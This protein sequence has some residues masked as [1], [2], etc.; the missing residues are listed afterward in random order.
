MRR[1]LYGAVLM[2]ALTGVV[3]CVGM[4]SK[5]GQPRVAAAA[6]ESKQEKS[7]MEVKVVPW[8][9]TQEVIDAASNSVRNNPAIVARL[10][11]TRSR[12]LTLEMLNQDVK[13]GK[14]QPPPTRF[15]ATFY[16]YTHDQTIVAEGSF[17]NPERLEIA[18][19][20]YQPLPSN[21]EFDEAVKILQQ[22]AKLG[23]AIQDGRLKTYPPMPPV[24]YSERTRGRL[25]RT[26]TV[27]LI[28]N[29]PGDSTLERQNEVVGVNLSRNAVLR[30]ATG[31]PPTSSAVKAADCS[32]PPSAGSS[33]GRGV[34]GQ[35]Q[36][37]ISQNG[38][39]LWN[40][41]AVRPSA[42]SGSDGSAIELINVQYKGKQV[43]KRAHLPI[44]NVLY[45]GNTCGPYR[46]WQYAENQFNADPTNGTNVAAGVR[47]CTVP[48]TTVL[49]SGNDAGNFQGIAYYTV[50]DETTL[51]TEMSAGWYRYICEW[52]FH[53]DGTISPRFGMG[54]TA[55][56]CTCSG[57]I[58][59]AYWRLDFDID[60]ASPNRILE[61]RGRIFNSFPVQTEGK[62]TRSTAN[63]AGWIVDNPTTGDAYLIRPNSNDGTSVGDTYARGDL[64]FL[65]YSPTEIDDSAV[66]TNTQANLDAFVT[67]QKISNTDVVVWYAIHVNH[68][69]GMF[70][71]NHP[72]NI[73]GPLV[74]GPDLVPLRW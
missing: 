44:L 17:A 57:H 64:W 3:V 71:V 6:A 24:L 37:T 46:D 63:A 49:E 50:G 39:P 14:D 58:H 62:R 45:D 28:A 61:P 7:P 27:G 65:Q 2:C 59:H 34:A 68:N 73:G 69:R 23:A 19:A 16:D 56:S 15:R 20:S 35:Y 47:S 18:D 48:A 31:A 9:P 54:A 52:G 21:D 30:Y 4:F 66:R 67:N 72:H 41:L 8:G 60:G 51:V 12:L 32:P 40:F 25:N 5:S 26:I 1:W 53:A 11:K 74:G 36:F 33:T 38:V 70:N 42:S 55:N 29:Q 22:D 10:E 43:L 13:N